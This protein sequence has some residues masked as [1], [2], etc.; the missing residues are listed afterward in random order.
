[1]P[2]ETAVVT[3]RPSYRALLDVPFLGRVVTSMSLARVAQ[4]M[5]GVAIVL[6]TL[7]QYDSPALAGIVT[8]ASILPG[9][10]FA[11]I[12]GTLLDRHGRIRLVIL[13]YVVAALSL[14]AIAVLATADLL[15]PWLL[16]AIAV[17]TSLTAIL[18]HVGL[19]TLFPIMVPRRLWERI[20]AVDSNG[21]VL[22][23]IVAPP[24]AAGIVA[25]AGPIVAMGAIAVPFT[26]AAISLIGVREPAGTPSSEG[27]ILANA[28][29]G[30]RYTLR[31]PTLRGLGVSISVVNIASGVATIVIPLLVLRVLGFSEFIV[32][33][34]FAVGGVS[35]MV[36]VFFFGRFDSRGREWLM[37]VVPLALWWLVMVMLLPAVGVFGPIAPAAG[38]AFVVASQLLGGVLTGPMDIGLFTVRQRRTDPALL[39]RAFAV[40]MAFNFLGFPIGAAIAGSLATQDIALAIGVGIVASVV[41]AVAAAVMIPIRQAAGVGP[42]VAASPPVPGS[43]GAPPGA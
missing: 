10:F 29:E 41:A 37:L 12:A 15:P 9:L 17:L 21:Y 2:A 27:G 3:A 13:D 25:V 34:V 5:L 6:F 19:R 30:L 7:D 42:V 26:L 4:S 14:V 11:P 39:G 35:G 8:F 24:L 16:V 32:G 28:W 31:N 22:A 1:M 43:S 33:L 38:L 36:S 20:N 40:S 18:S 23:T